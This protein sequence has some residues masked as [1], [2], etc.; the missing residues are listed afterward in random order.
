MCSKV[1]AWPN[2][3]AGV[4]ELDLEPS[5]CSHCLQKREGG[6]DH[7]FLRQQMQKVINKAVVPQS[8]PNV[9]SDSVNYVT[10][11]VRSNQ[12]SIRRVSTSHTCLLGSVQV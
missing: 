8:D 11:L 10:Q 3:A 5:G 12:P 6:K 4:R 7:L 1:S 9:Q 2:V